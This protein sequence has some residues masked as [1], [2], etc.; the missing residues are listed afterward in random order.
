MKDTVRLNFEFPRSEYPSLK[1]LCAKM[2]LSLKD[3][4]TQLIIEAIDEAEDQWLLTQ[5]ET[6]LNRIES[7]AEN[8]LSLEDAKMQVLKREISSKI[9]RK[10]GKIPQKTTSGRQKKNTRPSG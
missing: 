2:G 5:G 9:G 3:F 7:G 8:T 4:A 10:R 1:M 6:V